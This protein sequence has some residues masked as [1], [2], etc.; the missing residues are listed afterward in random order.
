MQGLGANSPLHAF[1]FELM[2]F[3]VARSIVQS[4]KNFKKQFLT[5]KALPDF[6]DKA[7]IEPVQKRVLIIEAFLLYSQNNWQLVFIFSFQAH[8]LAAL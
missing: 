6:K 8:R 3:W 7:L 5:G 1:S 4:Q 2:V